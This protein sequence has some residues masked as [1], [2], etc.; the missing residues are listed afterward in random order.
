M[1]PPALQPGDTIGIISPS[2]GAA[3][4]FSERREHAL[5][6]IEAL[7]LRWKLGQHALNV[8]GYVSG[9][10]EN[11]ATDIQAMFADPEV[12]AIVAAIGGDHSC[13]LLPLLDFEQIAAHPKI[14]MG[15]SDV[16]VLNV[17][18]WR[19]T[20]L[21]TFNGPALM[22]EFGEFPTIFDYTKTWLE[23]ILCSPTPAGELQ[24]ADS[25]TEEFL[26][27]E[28]PEFWRNPRKM[29]PSPGW[30]WLKPG[31]SQGVLIGGCIESMQHLR[32]TRFWPDWKDAF[33]FWETSDEKPEPMTIDS[34]LM[35]YEN[36]G[37]L[38]QL[39]GMLVG[40]PMKYSDEEKQALRDVILARTAK[41]DFPI[42]TDMDFGHTSPQLTLPIGCRAEIDS[43]Y[44]RVA[45]LD[46]AVTSPTR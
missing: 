26:D 24:P 32:G 35:D 11:R 12:K 20:D 9:T 22:T 13:H 37:V 14:F 16:T 15:F 29:Q 23:N 8:S 17:A 10:A 43:E 18:I 21:T 38:S 36:M 27:W 30:T 5:K 19:A 1:K 2:F 33:F 7:G 46:A 25:W 28:Q 34:L 42:V 44:R 45:I 41:Y 4:M 6:Q 40:R 3:G 31:R 39:S